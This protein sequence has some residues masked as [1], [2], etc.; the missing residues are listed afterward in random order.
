MVKTNPLGFRVE[1][2]VKEALERAAQDDERSVS[3]MA[4]RILKEWL[5]RKGYLSKSST[6]KKNA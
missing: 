5:M 6:P 1:P 3:S 2:E 4:E